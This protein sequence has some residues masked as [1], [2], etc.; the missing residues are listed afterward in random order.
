ML[1]CE[2]TPFWNTIKTG[3]AAK[4]KS[5]SLTPL[6]VNS[7]FVG[8]RPRSI[9]AKHSVSRQDRKTFVPGDE[10]EKRRIQVVTERTDHSC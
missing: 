10:D 1:H 2:E 9:S 5:L 7:G 8:R 3:I 6:T 4:T